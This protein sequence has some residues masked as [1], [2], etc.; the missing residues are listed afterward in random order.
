MKTKKT[1]KLVLNKTTISA[2]GNE[3]QDSI[4]GGYTPSKYTYCFCGETIGTTCGAKSECLCVSWDLCTE[5]T[6]TTEP[7]TLDPKICR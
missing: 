2:L 5:Y 6:C 7:T 1:V 4:R 3:Q